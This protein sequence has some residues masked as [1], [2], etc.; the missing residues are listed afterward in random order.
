[1]LAEWGGVGRFYKGSSLWLEKLKKSRFG[2]GEVVEGS[3]AQ[4]KELGVGGEEE[5][6]QQ[7]NRRRLNKI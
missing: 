4:G 6:G 7:G 2:R 5:G 3:Q 1:M